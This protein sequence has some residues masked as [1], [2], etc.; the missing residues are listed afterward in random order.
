MMGIGAALV[1]PAT[2]AVITNVFADARE[3]AKAIG[4]WSAVSGVAVAAGPIAGGWLLEHYWWGSV[5]FINVP[6]IVIFLAAAV[7]LL[8]ESR[9]PRPGR[10]DVPLDNALSGYDSDATL[11]VKYVLPQTMRAQAMQHL[12]RMNVT[13]A[14][15][16]PDLEGLAR[17]TAYELEVV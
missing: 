4:I 3:R 11:L 14:S 16:F 2:L 13:N 7:F 1:F 5:F 8:P 17:S 15:L 6:I 10:I 9:D 12:Y